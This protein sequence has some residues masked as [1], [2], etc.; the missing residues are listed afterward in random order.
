[1]AN[2]ASSRPSLTSHAAANPTPPPKQNPAIAAKVGFVDCDNASKAAT[3]AA[4]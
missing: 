4:S 2:I 1:M 3:F